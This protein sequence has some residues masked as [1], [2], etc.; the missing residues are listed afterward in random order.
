VLKGVPGV[1]MGK[2]AVI[3]TAF[4]AI[5]AVMPLAQESSSDSKDY[6]N[7]SIRLRR[8]RHE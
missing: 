1:N 6:N 2:I 4:L 5:A 8:N 3:L 7:L